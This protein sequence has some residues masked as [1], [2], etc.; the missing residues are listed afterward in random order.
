MILTG[1]WATL[2]SLS[3]ISGFF[4]GWHRGRLIY[5]SQLPPVEPGNVAERL[6]GVIERRTAPPGTAPQAHRQPIVPYAIVF[7]QTWGLWMA[8]GQIMY[9][10][11][12]L[13]QS[14]RGADLMSPVEWAGAHWWLVPV[15]CAVAGLLGFVWWLLMRD[16][17]EAAEYE[18]APRLTPIQPELARAIWTAPLGQQWDQPGTTTSPNTPHW[19]QDRA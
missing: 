4:V 10:G 17:H 8:A 3:L 9:W 19:Q 12:Q 13:V 7:F 5:R 11:V 1:G 14:L 15:A 18:P 2:T 16:R 6:V